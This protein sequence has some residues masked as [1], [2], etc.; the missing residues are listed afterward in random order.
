MKSSTS[1]LSNTV[2][3][4]IIWPTYQKLQSGLKK[5]FKRR[6][7]FSWTKYATKNSQKSHFS[8][9]LTFDIETC[10]HIRTLCVWE[11]PKDALKCLSPKYHGQIPHNKK[12]PRPFNSLVFGRKFERFFKFRHILVNTKVNKCWPKC[13]FRK[14]HIKS[15]RKHIYS[16]FIALIPFSQSLKVCLSLLNG[17]LL[18]LTFKWR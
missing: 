12:T 8:R 7:T 15:Y 11:R 2:S 4:V 10:T 14:D 3:H 1:Q 13:F 18:N 16:F 6:L 5:I 17:P 9:F